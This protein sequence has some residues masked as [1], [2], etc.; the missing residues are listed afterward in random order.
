M[1]RTRHVL[2]I[3]LVA[4]ALCADRTIAAAPGLGERPQNGGGSSVAGR[5][6]SRLSVSFRRVVS[7]T[8][9]YEARQERDISAEAGTPAQLLPNPTVALFSVRISPHLLRLPPPSL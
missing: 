9:V 7:V 4:T 6:V 8:R 2:A 5:L 1:N 3:A